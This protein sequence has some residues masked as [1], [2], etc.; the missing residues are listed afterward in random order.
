MSEYSWKNGAINFRKHDAN[1][2][3]AELTR[4]RK[5][6]GKLDPSDVVEASLDKKSVLHRIIPQGDKEAARLGREMVASSLLR[7]IRL[8]TETVGG[9]TIDTRAF[10]S[11]RD[12]DAKTRTYQGI[13]EALA[14]EEGRLYQLRAAWLQLKSWRH[15]YAELTELAD[16][17]SAIDEAL[18]KRSA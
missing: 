12:P 3:G 6:R 8:R 10:V 14:T 16:V 11:V 5:E 4:V 18:E 15:R 13:E 7:S 9:K 2:V 1:A 17:F